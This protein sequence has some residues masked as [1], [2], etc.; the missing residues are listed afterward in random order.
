M[1]KTKIKYVY[2]K[3]KPYIICDTNVWYEMG[4]GKFTKPNDYDLIPTVFSL[5]EIASSQAMV[6]QPKFYQDTIKMIYDNSGPIIPENPFDY[7]L[8][9]N[10]EDYPKE[11]DKS[12]IQILADFGKL[13]NKKIDNNTEIDTKLKEQV[14]LECKNRRGVS[15][16]LANIGN[17]DLIELRSNINKGLGKKEHLKI[18]TTEINKEM[19]KSF[20]NNYVM[21]KNYKIQ[22]EG[23]DWGKIELFMIV[24]EI[25]FKKLETTKDMKIK[26]NDIID[27][28]NLLYVSP[29]DKYLTFDK[30]WKNYI[31]N[32]NRINHY[33]FV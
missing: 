10:F 7:I 2:E 20:L 27:W 22:W 31:V 29:D 8:A 11:N 23:F 14:I 13:M 3:V 24:T 5:V 33:L 1:S 25:Y 16:D 12:L 17:E 6:E 21:E 28:F 18:D 19:L 26:T 4:A 32:D 9:N 15:Q 30:R